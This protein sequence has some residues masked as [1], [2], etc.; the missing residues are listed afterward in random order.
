M[1]LYDICICMYMYV[2]IY[3]YIYIYAR[4]R[5]TSE[6]STRPLAN[7]GFVRRISDCAPEACGIAAGGLGIQ[8]VQGVEAS[9][10]R[11]LWRK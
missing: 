8:R 2:C 5:N 1:S 10:A 4:D 6:V 9:G 7:E 11:G 3:I